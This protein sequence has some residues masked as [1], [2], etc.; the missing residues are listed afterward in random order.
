M[1]E[2]SETW[3]PRATAV[4]VCDVWDYH[5]SINAVRRMEEFG[6][7]INAVVSRARQLGATIIHAPSDCMPAYADHPARSRSLAVARAKNL[8]A[9]VEGW[10]SLVPGERRAVYPID[11]SDG[12]EDDDPQEHAAWAAKLKSLGR[13]PGMPWQ[14][15][16]D[17]I[18]IDPATDYLSDRGDEVWNILEACGIQHVILTGVH[19]N[20]CVLG[21]PFGLRR[22]VLGGKQVVLLRDVTDAMYNPASWPY[23]NH[24]T[25]NERVI[26]HVERYVCPTISSDQILGGRPFRFSA[27][28]RPHVAI[29]IA[30][31]G[32]G[33][34]R[35]LPDFATRHL[36]RDF[37]V[38]YVFARADDPH[39]LPGLDVLNEADLA[40]LSVRRRAL[41]PEAMAIVRRFVAAGKPVLGLRTASHAFALREPVPPLGCETWPDFDAQVFGGHF[42]GHS[43]SKAPA[44]IGLTAAA[45]E[46]P[47]SVGLPREPLRRAGGLYRFTALSPRATV[48]WEGEQEDYREPIAWTFTR[49]DGGRSFYTSLGES[50][51]FENP[52]FQRLLCSAVYWSA[53]RSIPQI[54]PILSPREQL[55]S[56][57]SNVD[58]PGAVDSQTHAGL[59][60]YEGPA[61]YRCVVRVPSSWRGGPVTLSLPG[62]GVTSEVWLNGAPLPA[63]AGT[64]LHG[65]PTRHFEVPAAALLPGDAN[66]IVVR[67]GERSADGI[68]SVP[69]AASFSSAPALRRGEET[70]S[71]AGRW[72]FRI[73]DDRGWSNMPLPAKFGASADVVIED[74]L[75]QRESR[76]RFHSHILPSRPLFREAQVIAVRREDAKISD[77]PRLLRNTAGDPPAKLHGRRMGQVEVGHHEPDFESRNAIGGLFTHSV[78]TV[79]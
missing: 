30:E 48:L 75:I 1:R 71:L 10:C 17:M 21:R 70:I 45:V 72:Q 2:R 27:D 54:L 42:D 24:F 31:E 58:V 65:S 46:H 44:T 53:D 56:H 7:R 63:N 61:W 25:G 41:R 50:I 18:E 16:S 12:G 74:A 51:D 13:N 57:W 43:P 4:I 33:T 15:Q 62:N 59:K 55:E 78:G 26:E 11:Q 14:R 19:V 3:D 32:Y 22:M 35:T 6:P 76:A 37:R 47:L 60:G 79:Q 28:R 8:P 9:D 64:L 40:L 39:E 38:S 29:V 34:V 66:L 68:S 69:A 36:G 52:A 20:M 77:A 67:R 49:A 73:G 5:H 23:V